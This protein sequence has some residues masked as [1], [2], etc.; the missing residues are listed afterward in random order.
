MVFVGYFAQKQGWKRTFTIGAV[1]VV[2]AA[3]LTTFATD[4]V[5]FI[6]MRS[7]AGVGTGFMFMALR[8]Y[9]NIGSNTSIRN[10]GFAQLTAGAVAGMNVGV[11]M[12]ANLADKI[13]MLS[14]FFVMAAFGVISYIFVLMQMRQPENLTVEKETEKSTIGIMKFYL[15]P[16][17]LLFFVAILIPAYIAGMYLEYFFPVYAEEQGLSTSVIGLAFTLYGLIIVYLGPTFAQLGERKLGIRSAAALASLLTGLSLLTFALTGN[18][19]GALIAVVILGFSDGF[20]EAAYNSYFLELEAAQAMGESSASGH[21]E[22]VGNIGKMIGPVVIA[23]MLTL[24]S[25]K[26]IGLIAVG[27]IALMAVFLLFSGKTKKV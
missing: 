9:V 24:G 23:V 20:G 25:Q 21:F 16:K 22:F 7:L 14:V 26:G 10:D 27:V 8:A 4:I 1:I 3:V 15:N 12:G 18:L 19:V 17:V 5:Y 11:V 2:I 6:G 13:G